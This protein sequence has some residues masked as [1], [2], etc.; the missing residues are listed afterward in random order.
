MSAHADLQD[1]MAMLPDERAPG[2]APALARQLERIAT[3]LEALAGIRQPAAI[4]F[5]A[6]I[7]FRWCGVGGGHRTAPLE[8]IATPALVGFDALRNV[9]RQA[10]IVERNTRQFV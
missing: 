7:A 3:A 4:D 6:A 2:A 1:L 10:A 5:D 8:P 9:G